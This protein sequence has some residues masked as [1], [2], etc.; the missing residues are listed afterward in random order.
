MYSRKNFK[1]E[2]CSYALKIFFH[3]SKNNSPENLFVFKIYSIE[4]F[5][6]R[7]AANDS[8]IYGNIFID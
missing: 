3:V 8:L 2:L 4:R 1:I 5:K 7:T 6:I